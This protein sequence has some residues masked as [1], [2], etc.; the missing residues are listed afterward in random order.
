MYPQ[1]STPLEL[2]TAFDTQLRDSSR[3]S[4][5]GLLRLHRVGPPPNLIPPSQSA[6]PR[7]PTVAVKVTCEEQLAAAA[8][9]ASEST[10]CA[11]AV[12][13][14]VPATDSEAT[15]TVHV[16]TATCT[17]GCVPRVRAALESGLAE[18]ARK[19]AAM[20]VLQEDLNL[21]G[22]KVPLVKN[23]SWILQASPS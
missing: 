22:G 2:W 13:A 12:A 18:C 10:A 1:D 9:L 8:A 17:G 19:W 14:L 6:S 21:A 15:N 3:P 4:A 11:A 7:A 20:P 5:A 16:P 23:T